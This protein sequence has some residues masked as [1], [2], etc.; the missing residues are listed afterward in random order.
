[1]NYF[2]KKNI[3]IYIYF[4]GSQTGYAKSVAYELFK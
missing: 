4:F 2:T 1:M 3:N